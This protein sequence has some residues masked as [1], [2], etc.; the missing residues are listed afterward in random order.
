V[1]P[2]MLVTEP[3]HYA[4]DALDTARMVISAIICS[5][6]EKTNKFVDM[7]LSSTNFQTDAEI[8]NVEQHLGLPPGNCTNMIRKALQVIL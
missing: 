8:H 7:A 6:R 5:S 2:G 3:S 4:V 1:P